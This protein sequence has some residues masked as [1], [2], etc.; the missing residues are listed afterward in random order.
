MNEPTARKTRKMAA[1]RMVPV[2]GQF[3]SVVPRGASRKTWQARKDEDGGAMMTVEQLLA[4]KAAFDAV[5]ATKAT[6][7]ADLAAAQ[8]AD[9]FAFELAQKGLTRDHVHTLVFD[10]SYTADSAAAWATAHG[11]T[12]AQKAEVDGEGA[13]RV[14]AVCVSQKAE[15]DFAQVTLDGVAAVVFAPVAPALK[16]D[17]LFGVLDTARDA[18]VA[19]ALDGGSAADIVAAARKFES[20]LAATLGV[21]VANVADVALAT[22]VDE[23]TA[24]VSQLVAASAAAPTVATKA[25]ITAMVDAA[26]ATAVPVAATTAA[27]AEVAAQSSG[28]VE[29]A[30]KAAQDIATK[31]ASGF[32]A[33]LVRV[34][35][36]IVPARKGADVNET[37][38]LEPG[39]PSTTARKGGATFD[40]AFGG[41]GRRAA[42]A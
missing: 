36:E 27:K 10:A 23:L 28:I 22:K 1:T 30:T 35:R 13:D 11:L 25:D 16:W 17:D 24:Q 26:I 19:S 3:V 34:E 21:E 41:L 18:V 8:A 32:D 38:V 15:G 6:L 29:A 4:K 40:S 37:P 7:D 39:I 2:E 33:R 31:A 14:I 42:S 12:P 9:P 5:M 20:D